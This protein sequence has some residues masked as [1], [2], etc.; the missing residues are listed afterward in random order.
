MDNNAE[1]ACGPLLLRELVHIELLD[2]YQPAGIAKTTQ[3]PTM[4]AHNYTFL[5]EVAVSK[6]EVI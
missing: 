3:L 6:P 5:L 4:L 2:T 1:Q